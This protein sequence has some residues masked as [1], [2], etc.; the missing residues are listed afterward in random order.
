MPLPMASGLQVLRSCPSSVTGSGH[1]GLH[2]AGASAGFTIG[3]E[4]CSLQAK[5]QVAQFT[6]F[7]KIF[8]AGR[9]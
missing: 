5:A 6:I 8:Y 3:E 1:N 7:R 2:R 4:F 9:F